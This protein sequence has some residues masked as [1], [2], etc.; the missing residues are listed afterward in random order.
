MESTT[1]LSPPSK[2]G[3]VGCFTGIFRLSRR[4]KS[5]AAKCPRTPTASAVTTPFDSS[6]ATSSAVPRPFDSGVT[7]AA[8]GPPIEVIV[9]RAPETP[10]PCFV[11][12][13]FAL[14]E[15]ERRHSG[16]H[17]HSRSRPCSRDESGIVSK[18]FLKPYF[19]RFAGRWMTFDCRSKNASLFVNVKVRVEG[20]DMEPLA[21]FYHSSNEGA[22]LLSDRCI[23]FAHELVP[24]RS[25]SGHEISSPKSLSFLCE[26]H[27]IAHLGD[28]CVTNLPAR[29][30]DRLSAGSTQEI[31]V[32]VWPKS[33][34]SS[35]IRLKV[36]PNIS[37]RELQW[38]LC[39]HLSLSTPRFMTLYEQNCLE[40]LKPEHPLLA[41]QTHLE[42]TLLPQ[43]FELK[44]P[45][46][47]ANFPITVSLIGHG[48]NEVY[49][50]PAMTLCE[51]ER[52]IRQCF[53]LKSD[54]FLYLPQV[55]KSQR[56]Y[57]SGLKMTTPLDCS[58]LSLL[59]RERH[60]PVIN[61]MPSLQVRETYEQLML[62]QMTLS[63]LDL[64]QASPVIAFEV[65][66]P[67]IPLNFRTVRTQGQCSNVH[68][69]YEVFAIVSMK[70]HA[71][72]IN[73]YWTINTLLK[74]IESI[75]GFPAGHIHYQGASIDKESSV[76]QLLCHKWTTSSGG[77]LR[78]VN[79]I[80]QVM[81]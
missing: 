9:A 63:G 12:A 55:F 40:C 81:A 22:D 20:Y 17:A 7:S 41:T 30:R 70:C 50:H 27:V 45:A 32:R 26:K 29:L 53:A 72:S 33:A 59:G 16:S 69:S 14:S 78:L 80:P 19:G 75:S 3:R 61:G 25:M 51:F 67:T 47:Q 65:T 11:L 18:F 31:S 8:A 44:K 39:E 5:V 21:T 49:A 77:R 76:G 36:K 28:L 43:A 6:V 35:L 42:C 13:T 60:C 57:Q 37:V 73:P 68:S 1:P 10:A 71:V 52:E 54:S 66:G 34:C 62:Y 58:T 15:T 4:K 79:D 74:Y 46:V 64:L 2:T 23:R 38:M 48:V 56:S 24:V